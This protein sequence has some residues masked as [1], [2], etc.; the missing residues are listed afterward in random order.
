MVDNNCKHIKI[1]IKIQNISNITIDFAKNIMR[2]L[3]IRQNTK[4]LYVTLTIVQEN[5]IK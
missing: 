3:Q 5:N 1:D 2:N 4:Y